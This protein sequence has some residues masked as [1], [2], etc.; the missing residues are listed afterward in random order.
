[1]LSLTCERNHDQA[2]FHNM[3]SRSPLMKGVFDILPVVAQTPATALF[4]GR[5]R[6]GQ[7]AV[8][9][10]SRTE[11]PQDKPFVAINCSALPDN[12]LE[13]EPVRV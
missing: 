13:S 2:S 9:L 8:A 5:K 7:G 4:T 6:H 11:P 3:V 1:M 10:P 12:L